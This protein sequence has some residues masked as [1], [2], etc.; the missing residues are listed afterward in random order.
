MLQT[1]LEWIH[2]GSNFIHIINA[3]FIISTWWVLVFRRR[4]REKKLYNITKR[5]PGQRP[6]ALIVNCL[7]RGDITN[8]VK[9][10]IASDESLNTSVQKERIFILN[11]GG[12]ALK[13]EDMPELALKMLDKAGEILGSGCDVLHIFYGGPVVPA[14]VLGG[15]FSN[16]GDVRLYHRT[17]TPAVGPT[18]A[19]VTYEPWGRLTYHF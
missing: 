10:F 18:G 12:K 2:H 15:V 1:V 7:E 13:S 8:D 5:H 9:H 14:I 3:V 17:T 19:G 6:A 16:R 11:A 4:H